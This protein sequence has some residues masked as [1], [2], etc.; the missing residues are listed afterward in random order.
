MTSIQSAG[1][2]ARYRDA[3][4]EDT[5]ALVEG[6]GRTVLRGMAPDVRAWLASPKQGLVAAVE[7]VHGAED[8]TDALARLAPSRLTVGATVI[9]DD[10]CWS[11]ITRVGDGE[12][13]TCLAGLAYDA[14]GRVS[15]LIWLRAPLVPAS[16]AGERTAA[17]DA[18]PLLE[19][20]FTDLMSSRFTEA[21]S[22]FTADTIY[23][24]P[25]YAG[26]GR[27]VL[28][29][30]RE[31]LRRGFET[32]RGPSPARQIITEFSQQGARV[33][34]EGIIEGNPD[35]GSFFSTAEVSAGGEIARY[36]AFYIAA[37]IPRLRMK[38]N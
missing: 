24:H 30:G 12:P 29:R 2:S 3:A 38:P 19:Q 7:S 18:R 16:G 25:P 31:A 27:R 37:R 21:A 14:A 36:V 23:S 26:G 4:L 28:F 15:R 20:Y 13:E 11:E 1:G 10:A 9:S 5:L 8:V 6:A 35:G 17:P 22:H 32:E 33:F 34:V